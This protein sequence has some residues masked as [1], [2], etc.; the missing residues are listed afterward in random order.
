MNKT[1]VIVGLTAMMALS[2]QAQNRKEDEPQQK[3]P[4]IQQVASA[5]KIIPPLGLREPAPVDTLLL[6][7]GQRSV[8]SAQ[9]I[10]YATTGNPGGAGETLLFLTGN[11]TARFFSMMRCIT[12][13]RHLVHSGSITPEYR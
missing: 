2:G 1:V 7:Y 4:D 5:W 9:S 10:A 12:G 13:Y 11:R 6:N 3:G 8:P